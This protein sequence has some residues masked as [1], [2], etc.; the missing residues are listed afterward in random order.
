MMQASCATVRQFGEIIFVEHG[1]LMRAFFLDA[2]QIVEYDKPTIN[3]SVRCGFQEMLFQ[4]VRQYFHD[5]V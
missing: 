2:G 5:E 3:A 1:R 4:P